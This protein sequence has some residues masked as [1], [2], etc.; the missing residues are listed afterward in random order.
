LRSL[1]LFLSVWIQ[2][3]VDNSCTINVGRKETKLTANRVPDGQGIKTRQHAHEVL[4][5][6]GLY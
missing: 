4:A 6:R 3:A 5:V 2:W 1:S